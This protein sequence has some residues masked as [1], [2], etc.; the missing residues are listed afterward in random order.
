MKNF[1][2]KSLNSM[3]NNLRFYSLYSFAQYEI[4]KILLTLIFKKA[5]MW[6]TQDIGKRQRAGKL[7]LGFLLLPDKSGESIMDGKMLS[8]VTE[9]GRLIV[10]IVLSSNT[11]GIYN[12][13]FLISLFCILFPVCVFRVLKHLLLSEAKIIFVG[14]Q[15]SANYP[16]TVDSL[17]R[18]FR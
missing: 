1:L 9:R 10:S 3:L 12:I 15:F 11:N 14:S 13:N 5:D 18:N 6:P 16:P 7:T 2:R 17:K 4:M 8:T